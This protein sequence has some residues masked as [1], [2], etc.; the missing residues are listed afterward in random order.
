MNILGHDLSAAERNKVTRAIAAAEKHTS[1]EIVVVA[2]RA[3]DDYIHVPI[4]LAAG[5][6][7][8]VPLLV[9]LF[10]RFAPWSAITVS[11]L[12][13]VQLCVFILVALLFS[14]PALRYAVTP[15]RLMRK[16]A[17]RHAAAQFLASN[18][19]ATK[20]RTGILIFVSL[21]ER[22][23]EVIGDSGIAA[24]LSQRDWQKIV[25][26]IVPLLK[27]KQT[28]DALT[29]AVQLS[30]TLLARHFPAGHH[31]P[32]ELPDRFIVIE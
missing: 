18:I 24:K 28:A 23:V 19:V 6:A 26:E 31:N 10:A 15:M 5:C 25:D 12:F 16:Y 4:H 27:N 9:P 1:G 2:A 8:A 11:T 14:L 3:S 21:L 13:L 7:L 20:E 32:N 29:L 30:G 22:Y 17:H